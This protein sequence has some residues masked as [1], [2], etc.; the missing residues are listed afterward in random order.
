M[1]VHM[2]TYYISAVG[3][4]SN[5][6][7]DPSSPWQTLA[8]VAATTLWPGDV[9]LFRA[10]DAFYGIL[11]CNYGAA[12]PRTQDVRPIMC[13]SYGAGAKPKISYYKRLVTGNW[14]NEGGGVWSFPINNNG[15]VVVTG[16]YTIVGANGANIG[17]LRVDSQIFGFKRK[18]LAELTQPLQPTAQTE[19]QVPRSPAQWDFFSNEVDKLY[20]YSPAGDPS[21]LATEI[22]AAPNGNLVASNLNG[23][24]ISGLHFEGSGGHCV[25]SISDC[26][27]ENN[28]VA[29]I[30]GSRLLADGTRYGNGFQNYANGGTQARCRIRNNEFRDIYDVAFTCQG[31]NNTLA[32]HGFEDIDFSQNVILR[33]SQAYEFW[34][35]SG[36]QVAD[37]A[38]DPNAGFRRIRVVGNQD[39]DTGF[40][41]GYDTRTDQLAGGVSKGVPLLC[42]SMLVPKIDIIIDR[43]ESYNPRSLAFFLTPPAPGY[44]WTNHRVFARPGTGLDPRNVPGSV[45]DNFDAYILAT[46]RGQGSVFFPLDENPSEL[47]VQSNVQQILSFINSVALK[48]ELLEDALRAVG[49]TASQ[50]LESAKTALLPIFSQANLPASAYGSGQLA[51]VTNIGGSGG[52]VMSLFNKWRRLSTGGVNSFSGAGNHTI[53]YPL[54]ACM[55]KY[56]GDQTTSNANTILSSPGQISGAEIELVRT[57]TGTGRRIVQATSAAGTSVNLV[58][59]GQNSWAKFRGDDGTPYIWHVVAWGGDVIIL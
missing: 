52:L 10:G 17:F 19:W 39:I 33:C 21:L 37:P 56:V 53:S 24:S 30:G 34:A 38:A 11:Q 28:V 32:T 6:G 43:N 20:V 44:R 45:V 1:V 5:T 48:T 25:G 40:C 54:S 46:G 47:D 59:L 3:D 41:W 51:Y 14:T 58:S 4:D 31:P 13:S 2:S 49:G 15:G 18:T 16:N 9:I 42:Y 57:A 29:E 7:R 55:V 8:K 22:L 35:T 26:L 36:N 23:M 27:F 50:A 12:I